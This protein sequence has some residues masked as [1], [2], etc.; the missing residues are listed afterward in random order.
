VLNNV[1][2][3]TSIPDL[4]ASN[5]W[6]ER[7]YLYTPST[8]GT[9]NGVFQYRM[10][11]VSDWVEVINVAITNFTSYMSGETNRDR[12]VIFQNYLGNGT[13][14]NGTTARMDGTFVQTGGQQ[15]AYLT[16]GTKKH[17]VFVD[18][19]SSSSTNIRFRVEQGILSS[20]TGAQL[21]VYDSSGSASS[22]YTPVPE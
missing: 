6:Y 16:D 12:Y 14:A 9:A 15:R 11:R 22:P 1:D 3:N 7:E 20:L 13:F 17:Q 8:P 5:V 19:T 18:K 21:I 4:I 10:R 2:D